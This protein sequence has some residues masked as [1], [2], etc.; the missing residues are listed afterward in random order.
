MCV[1]AVKSEQADTESTQ[2]A[3]VTIYTLQVYTR[4]ST[5]CRPP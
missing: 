5:T 3:T 1:N 4:N 2:M